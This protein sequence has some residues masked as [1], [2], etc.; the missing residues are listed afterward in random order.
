M[1]TEKKVS[2]D[3]H[4]NVD[5]VDV[6]IDKDELALPPGTFDPV[7]EAKARVLNRAVSMLSSIP[8]RPDGLTCFRSRTSAWAGTS[9]NSSLLSV[10]DGPVTMRGRLSHHFSVSEEALTL[11]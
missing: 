2:S 7:Y 6:D 3:S 8:R 5:I 11:Y 4:R 1:T 9:G 10:S